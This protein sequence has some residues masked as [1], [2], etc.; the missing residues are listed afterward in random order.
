MGMSGKHNKVKTMIKKTR[1]EI[2]ERALVQ[3]V[4]AGEAER[5]E[6][7]AI[8]PDGKKEAKVFYKLKV[9]KR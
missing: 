7:C 1:M 9:S 5:H 2:V 8:G 4:K 6:L 3:M